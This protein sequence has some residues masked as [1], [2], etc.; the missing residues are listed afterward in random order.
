MEPAGVESYRTGLFT[1]L[2]LSLDFKGLGGIV[3]NMDPTLGCCGNQLLTHANV[4]AS[5]CS[6][7]EHAEDIFRLDL[8]IISIGQS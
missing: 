7:V 5:N 4:H 6:W 3:V 2:E 8:H 1:R